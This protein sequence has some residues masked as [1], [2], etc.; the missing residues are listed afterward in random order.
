MTI[1]DLHLDKLT[2]YWPEANAMQL[3]HVRSVINTNLL[4]GI[5]NVLF[6]GDIAEGIRDTTG[7]KV[8]LSEDAQVQLL[9]FFAEFD[10]KVQI[11]VLLGNHDLAERG[12]HSLQIFIAAQKAGFFKT[13]RFY[14]EPTIIKR[15]GVKI[16]ALP[17]PHKVPH[18]EANFGIAHYEVYGA[19]G[20]S[21]HKVGGEEFV[22][23]TPIVQGHL[24]TPQ[25]VRNHRYPGT[26]YQL[27]F[28]ERL[29]KGYGVVR[30][31][32][33]KFAYKWVQAKP[34]FEL[35]NVRIEKVSD[36]D[37]LTP[38]P[39]VLQK[40]FVPDDIKIPQTLLQKYPNIVNALQY[41]N[42]KELASLEAAELLLETTPTEINQE[43]F[44]VPL[45][46]NFG[47]TKKQINRALTI[48]KDFV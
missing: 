2:K 46:S 6:L 27:S 12:S 45:L 20:D 10:G 24:H 47:A 8:R 43:E 33:E 31:T 32:K 37:A 39:K 30:A 11:D 5:T 13:V 48:L 38:D 1:G 35:R 29:P 18:E 19:L 7:N 4:R 26:L 25:K 44:L 14:E 16:S 36:F 22:F 17:F 28:G 21:G 42:E 9:H 3:G 41:S 40:L 23:D 34:P 15:D